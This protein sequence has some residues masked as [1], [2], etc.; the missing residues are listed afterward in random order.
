MSKRWT[1][2]RIILLGL[3]VGLCL[4]GVQTFVKG[5][6]MYREYEQWQTANPLYAPIDLSIHGRHVFRFDQ[7]CSSAHRQVIALHIPEQTLQQT[8]VTQLVSGLSARLEI[9][10]TLNTNIVASAETDLLWTEIRTEDTIPIFDVSPFGKGVYEATIT[11]DK[12]AAALAGIPQQLEGRYELCGL[13]AMPAMICQT[14]GAATAGV[15]GLAGFVIVLGARPNRENR[16]KA[17]G[18]SSA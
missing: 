11:I 14:V 4:W 16:K 17:D 12:G 6:H 8:S 2:L 18:K 9:T 7:T 15:G 3:A 5:G 10:S 1:S 13:E